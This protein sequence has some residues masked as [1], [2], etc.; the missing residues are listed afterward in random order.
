MVLRRQN[1]RET[2]GDTKGGDEI[3]NGDTTYTGDNLSEKT[4]GG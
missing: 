4:Q 1:I 3:I 2:G